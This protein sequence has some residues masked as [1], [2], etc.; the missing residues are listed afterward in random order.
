M[1]PDMDQIAGRE[2]V[3]FAVYNN[4]NFAFQNEKVFFHYIV[5]MSK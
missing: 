3:Y 1:V 5:V 2:C 4:I